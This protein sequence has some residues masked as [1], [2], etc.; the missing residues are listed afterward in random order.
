[1]REVYPPSPDMRMPSLSRDEELRGSESL[2]CPCEMSSTVTFGSNARVLGSCP[3]TR[4]M[5]MP[6]RPGLFTSPSLVVPE[7][8]S[9]TA[10]Q[11]AYCAQGA[12]R[13]LVAQAFDE[14]TAF[15]FSFFLLVSFAW[16]KHTNEG[17]A[18]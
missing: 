11:W 14:R 16:P 10:I 15:L 9:N 6:S 5:P 4:V 13:F 2:C 18:G 8:P 17:P 3:R 1:M 12:Y 7:T